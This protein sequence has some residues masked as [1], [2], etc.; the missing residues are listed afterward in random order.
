MDPVFTFHSFPS[1]T[2]S[3]T[4]NHVK[5]FNGKFL[6]IK[7]Q[8]PLG[9]KRYPACSV[10]KGHPFGPRRGPY[11]IAGGETTGNWASRSIQAPTGRYKID[12]FYRACP[13]LF[14]C[15]VTSAW[16]PKTYYIPCKSCLFRAKSRI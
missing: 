11:I 15:V 4:D 8:I 16:P 9:N 10:E 2:I 1:I 7:R 14:L 13:V 3:K 12:V 5:N 6:G